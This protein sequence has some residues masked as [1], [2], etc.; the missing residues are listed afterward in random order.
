[1]S[2][3]NITPVQSMFADLSSEL[4]ASRRVLELVPDG[5]NDWRPHDKSLFPSGGSPRIW[6]S[7]RNSP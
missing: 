6:Q 2:S 4:A 7:C 3:P 1:M 5:N